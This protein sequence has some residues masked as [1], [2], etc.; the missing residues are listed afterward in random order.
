[1]LTGAETTHLIVEP[2]WTQAV[3]WDPVSLTCQGSGTAGAATWY[4]DGQRWVEEGPNHFIVFE[5]GT[6]RC[7]KP[8]SG[9]SSSVRV[10]NG[11][12]GMGIGLVLQVSA[13]ALVEG[14]TVTLCCRAMQDMSGSR[15]RFYQDGKD[16][17]SPLRG[18][19][20]SLSPLQLNH[21]GRYHC[22]A[23]M[24][25]GLSQS[26]PVTVTSPSPAG[27][28]SPSPPAFPSQSSSRC[29]Y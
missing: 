14:D 25:F 20:L 7:E 21:S 1:S 12:C 29:G 2:C 6:Y 17:G 26:A 27:S 8:G 13:W 24:S 19:E 22:E 28:G 23:M 5:S 3:L 11:E 16:L 15:V 4:K 9:L 18:T 10:L